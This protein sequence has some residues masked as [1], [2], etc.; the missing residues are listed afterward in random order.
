MGGDI[1]SF[2]EVKNAQTGK[3]EKVGEV[4]PLDEYDRKACNKEFGDSPFDWRSYSMYG[5]LAGVRNYSHCEPLSEPKGLPDDLSPEVAKE[6]EEWA[7]DGHSHSWLT[8]KELLAFDYDKTFRDKR[9]TKQVAPDFWNDAA[10][11]EEGE[12]AHVTYRERLGEP[13][14]RALEVLKTLG[15]P[16]N[17]RVV[18]WFDN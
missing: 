4:F 3:W 7:G 6:A 13:F 10:L 17:V 16:E 9:V 5:F 14:F 8:L 15:E 2:A 18:F 11:A 1:H 12:G